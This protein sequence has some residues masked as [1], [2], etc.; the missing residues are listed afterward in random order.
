M[1]ETIIA[2]VI[3]ALFGYAIIKLSFN[4]LN[5]HS[6]KDFIFRLKN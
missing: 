6:F 3:I 4:L 1:N 5:I 2:I